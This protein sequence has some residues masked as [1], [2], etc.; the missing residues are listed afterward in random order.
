MTFGWSRHGLLQWGRDSMATERAVALHR[1]STVMLQW[2]RDSMATERA[3]STRLALGLAG[4][5]GAV[6]LWPRK[7]ESFARDRIWSCFNGAVT[8]WPRKGAVVRVSCSSW[9]ASMGP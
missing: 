5:N 7:A 1:P 8:L 9:D 4:F 3:C 6:T 2:G